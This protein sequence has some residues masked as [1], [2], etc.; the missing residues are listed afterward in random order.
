MEIKGYVHRVMATQAISEK[1]AKREF[2]IKTNDKYPQLL[3]I[4]VIN[5]K[6]ALLD[7]I[8]NGEHVTAKINLRGREWINKLG[9]A[10]YFNTIEAWSVVYS[11]PDELPEQNIE[12]P[13]KSN[14]GNEMLKKT[15]INESGFNNDDLPF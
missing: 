8:Q 1:F 13:N 7:N 9:E 10:K 11:T 12:Q 3:T 5:D 14:P 15:I 2:V 6:C 4:Q